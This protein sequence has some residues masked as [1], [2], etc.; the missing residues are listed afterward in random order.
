MPRYVGV[1]NKN[2]CVV[3]NEKFISDE[4]NVIEVKKEFNYI[5][6]KELL[7]DYKFRDNV[8]T[9]KYRNKYAK[10]LKVAFITNWKMKCGISTFAESLYPEII[11]HIADYKLFIEKND[12]PTGQ[13]NIHDDKISVCWERGK[14]L[15]ELIRQIKE[16][17]PDVV[18]V[19]HE[20]GIFP[21]A[22]YWLSMMNQL[23]EFRI[24]TT[25]HSVFHHKDKTIVEA[26][27]P[28]IVVHLEGAA[29]VLREEKCIPGKVY[30]IPHG[31]V[32]FIDKEEIW[33]FYKSEHIF[34][35]AGFGFS[36]KGLE[37]SIIATSILKKK[38]DDVYFTCLFSESQYN[39]EGHDA[40]YDRLMKLISELDLEE[41]VGIIRGFQ[42]DQTLNS[43]FRM[44]KA[45]VFPYISHPEH[46]V[47]GASGAARFAMS[48]NIPVIT[49]SINHFSD[50]PTIKADTSEALAEKI[51]EIFSN[52][53]AVKQQL[54]IQEEY[55]NST[56]WD[57]IALKYIDLL[58]NKT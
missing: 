28:E 26:S 30:I 37:N 25:M 43:Y 55:L 27:I 31:S 46:E 57:K 17:D 51:D 15:K 34:I 33:N 16:Y 20:F 8:L 40:Y 13:I 1:R 3:S 44:N 54:A 36:Y 49:S 22:R 42:S 47:W 6:D 56:S 10:E 24:I 32:S 7:S 52:K 38:Y 12:Q 53:E 14:S 41:N 50:L 29:K 2:I 58:E 45:A 48:K 4:L 11:K 18:L 19:N 35:Q 5:T 9:P 39:K 21:N 23:S